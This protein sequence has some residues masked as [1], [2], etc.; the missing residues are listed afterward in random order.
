MNV[1]LF[2]EFRSASSFQPLICV[3][4][5]AEFLT[6]LRKNISCNYINCMIFMKDILLSALLDDRNSSR[7]EDAIIEQLNFLTAAEK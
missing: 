7:K 6:P 3:A 4:C 5:S 2:I 1:Q